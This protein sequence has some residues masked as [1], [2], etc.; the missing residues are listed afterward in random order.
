M[1]PQFEVCRH[2]EKDVAV[3]LPP[4]GSRTGAPLG[5]TFSES[6]GITPRR[7]KSPRPGARDEA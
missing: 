3:R 7:K 5:F 6:T 4:V 1:P 2:L